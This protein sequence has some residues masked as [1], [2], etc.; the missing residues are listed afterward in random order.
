MATSGD[1]RTGREIHAVVPE[2]ENDDARVCEL[3]DEIHALEE[4]RRSQLTLRKLSSFLK[5]A[6]TTREALVAIECYGPQLWPGAT[7]A[8]Y[9]LQSAGNY[10]ER[11]A[12]WGE[13]GLTGDSLNWQACWSMRSL[14]PHFV[15]ESSN[16]LVC[17]HVAQDRAAMP[18]LCVPLVAHGQLWGLM[19]LQRMKTDPDEER[20]AALCAAILSLAEVVAEDLSVAHGNVKLRESLREQ[21]IRDPLTGLFN[22]RFVDEFL[23]QELVRSQRKSRQLSM[24]ALDIDYFKRINDSFGHE[25]GDAVLQQVSTILQANVRGSDVASRVGGEEF[26]LLLAESPLQQATLRAEGIRDTISRMLF[27]FDEHELGP[28]TASFGAAAF[29]DHGRTP[30]ALRRAVDKA[31]YEAKHNG[32]N[33]VVT[34]APLH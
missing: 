32:R 9:L 11:A 1:R 13:A 25:A 28:I 4:F 26:L 27:K 24:I 14:K 31:L 33:R 18:S 29:P 10:L 17:E 7:G 21:S 16:E 19:H 12:V 8:V 5:S 22:R 34:A 3:L 20:R 30:E 15:H 2:R 6:L 23:A